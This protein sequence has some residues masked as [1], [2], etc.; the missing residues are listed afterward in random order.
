MTAQRQDRSVGGRGLAAILAVA[1]LFVLSGVGSTGA[2][3]T[4][5][6]VVDR[7]TGL[8]IGGIDPVAYFTDRTP[9]SGS[10]DLEL[11]QSGAVW[12]FRNEGNRATFMASPE[13]YGPQFGGYDP[14]DVARGVVAAGSPRIWLI[15]GQRL[16]LFGCEENRA[17]FGAAAASV[18]RDAGR[19]WP[20]L[21]AGLVD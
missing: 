17:A 18:A 2:A 4:E 19:R 1:G 20:D 6:V 11:S 21:R 9:L 13:I 10:A 12:R 15:V 8:A 3:T 5:Q 16:Y 14:V 7:H